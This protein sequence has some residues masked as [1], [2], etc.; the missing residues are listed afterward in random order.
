MR[1]FKL[2]TFMP[3]I[4]IRLFNKY[5]YVVLQNNTADLPTV[6]NQRKDDAFYK[7]NKHIIEI[8]KNM[9]FFT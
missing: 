8:M 6:S 9:L 1:L 3:L 4:Y 7:N 2:L 5:K